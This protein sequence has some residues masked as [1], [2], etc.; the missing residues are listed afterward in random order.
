LFQLENLGGGN[1]G[2]YYTNPNVVQIPAWHR[3]AD[4]NNDGFLDALVM[5][6]PNN[7]DLSVN[8]SLGLDNDGFWRGFSDIAF[9]YNAGGICPFVAEDFDGD[10]DIDIITLNN[11]PLQF[12]VNRFGLLRNTGA[13]GFAE[14]E[15]LATDDYRVPQYFVALDY[16]GDGDE[17]IV[18]VNGTGDLSLLL[19]DGAGN[20]ARVVACDTASALTATFWRDML[21][22]DF[23]NDGRPDVAL[24]HS[25]A[26]NDS[27]TVYLNA[28]WSLPTSVNDRRRSSAP[29]GNFV[30]Y[31]NYPNPFNPSTAIRFQLPVKSHVT[32]KVFD[33]NG[34]EVAMLFSDRR[35]AGTHEVAWEANG[36][37]SGLYFYRLEVDGLVQTMKLT[38]M[39]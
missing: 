27:L 1:Y 21:S 33:V 28:G 25:N 5:D 9:T 31:Q 24:L 17:D 11:E 2:W 22:D 38:L 34:R 14:L 13:G 19:N 36:L 35:A 12:G 39:K 29:I 10:N 16:E 7:E 4:V 37:P 23:N 26:G 20:F 15:T 32:L 30:L 6:S 18:T 8:Y 3:L